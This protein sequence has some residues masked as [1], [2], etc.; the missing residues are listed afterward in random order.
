MTALFRKKVSQ[1]EPN[2]EEKKEE[3]IEEEEMKPP[4]YLKFLCLY[5]G[6]TAFMGYTV[7]IN[8]IDFFLER[9][10]GHP[11]LTQN[12]ARILNFGAVAAQI[13]CFPFVEKIGANIRILVSQLIYALCF[14]VML[15]YMNI[16]EPISIPIL[17][18]VLAFDGVFFGVIM[19]ST[20]GFC[21]LLAEFGAPF[22]I[23]GNALAGVFFNSS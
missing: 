7:C 1:F 2:E 4:K 11:E 12:V 19:T 10:P 15:T 18:T 16:V 23:I 6:A 14:L 17:Y 13:L 9:C 22:A 8:A 3:E 20:N 21:G 5:L